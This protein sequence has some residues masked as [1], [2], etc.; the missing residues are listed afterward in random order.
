MVEGGGSEKAINVV[1]EYMR[2]DY[3][4]RPRGGHWHASIDNHSQN[5]LFFCMSF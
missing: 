5:T 3:C 4:F 1:G 2:R